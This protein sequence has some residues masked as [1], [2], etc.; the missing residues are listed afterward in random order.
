MSVQGVLS[1][2]CIAAYRG[3]CLIMVHAG[4][5]NKATSFTLVAASCGQAGEKSCNGY[6]RA[7]MHQVEVISAPTSPPP[8]PKPKTPPP[9]LMCPEPLHPWSSDW[10][11]NH[12][13]PQSEVGIVFQKRKVPCINYPFRCCTLPAFRPG[14][15]RLCAKSLHSL[16]GKA[17]DLNPP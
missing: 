15:S 2:K 4:V 13:S 12:S 6:L 17:G 11:L 9:E 1:S 5:M 8:P 3:S 16:V 14:S 10:C 7:A